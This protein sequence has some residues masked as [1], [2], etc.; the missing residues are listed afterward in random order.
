MS[1][2]SDPSQ[3]VF[4]LCMR[5]ND[6]R[7]RGVPLRRKGQLGFGERFGWMAW[8]AT[9]NLAALGQ[10]LSYGFLGEQAG[11]DINQKLIPYRAPRR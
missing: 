9:Q 10:N 11:Y 5:V 6:P 7:Y 3:P 4:R 1:T 8:N 2:L